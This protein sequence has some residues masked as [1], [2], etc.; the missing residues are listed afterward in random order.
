MSDSRSV[1]VCL[2][3]LL[4][5]A[6]DLGIPW[7]RILS[8]EI[9][10]ERRLRECIA[11]VGKG[12]P[13]WP[14]L[15]ILPASFLD[16]WRVRDRIRILAWLAS[17][18]GCKTSVRHLRALHAHLLGR[19]NGRGSDAT[20]FAKHLWF[21]Y[22]RV[23][24]LLRTCRAAERSNGSRNE[25]IEEVRLRTG[26]SARDAHWALERALAPHRDHTLDDAMRRARDEGFELPSEGNE[27][28]AFRR[29]RSFVRTSPHL[30]RLGNRR[31][32]GRG[33]VPPAQVLDRV[34]ER[35]GGTLEPRT[36]TGLP[37]GG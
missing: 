35:G 16:S 14:A 10:A 19:R 24:S 31:E 17:R 7:Q 21:G 6:D 18:E 8:D 27:V 20:L 11:D 5:E 37:R 25:R 33:S 26:C 12:W 3:D 13:L 15:S 30:V 1:G 34:Q 9:R 4:R 28:R 32:N 2:P 23:L 22:Q 29:L 36:E